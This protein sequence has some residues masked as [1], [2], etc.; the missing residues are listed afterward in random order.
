ML[1][2]PELEQRLKE[3]K[4]VNP[5]GH[6][7]IERCFDSVETLSEAVDPLSYWENKVPDYPL[8]SSITLD[9]LAVPA[10]PAPVEWIFST[11]GDT[12]IGK[13]NRLADQNLKRNSA[14]KKQALSLIGLDTSCC[15]FYQTGA[16][17]LLWCVLTTSIY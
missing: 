2:P 13:K 8:L 10:S 11:A 16:T 7:E 9:I 5:P 1:P 14:E 6:T 4:G 15:A 17:A 12:T 3:K